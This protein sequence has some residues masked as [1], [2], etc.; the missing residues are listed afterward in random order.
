MT[1][2]NDI[3]AEKS[4]SISKNCSTFKMAILTAFASLLLE[5]TNSHM[6]PLPLV[7]ELSLQ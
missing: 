5:I 7:D 6:D 1:F 3:I 2:K 4:V